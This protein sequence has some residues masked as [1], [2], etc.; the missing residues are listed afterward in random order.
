MIIN[1]RCL[2][3]FYLLKIHNYVGINKNNDVMYHI[4]I[5]N[6]SQLKKTQ[7]KQGYLAE[8]FYCE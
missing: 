3:F 6:D 1:S 7:E 2:T 8:F 5:F 4:D